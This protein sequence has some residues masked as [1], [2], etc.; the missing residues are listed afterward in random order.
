MKPQVKKALNITSYVL[1]G[2]MFAISL[3]MVVLSLT[4]SSDPS[5]LY[6]GIP[7]IGGNFLLSVQTDSMKGDKKD[8]FNPGA[9]VVSRKL[10]IS[11]EPDIGDIISFWDYIGDSS[12]QGVEIVN[13]HRVVG[14]RV[15][16][17]RDNNGAIINPID[18]DDKAAL[19]IQMGQLNFDSYEFITRGDNT[20]E[21][22]KD[23]VSHKRAEIIGIYRFHVGGL[24]SVIEF[25]LSKWGFFCVVI[26]PLL[27]FVVYRGFKL[28]MLILDLQK[29]KKV[30][31]TADDAL[32]RELEEL[33]RKVAAQGQDPPA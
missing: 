24:G 32:L 28:V 6:N 10:K 11:E 8:S 1:I 12:G 18:V 30:G 17:K 5:P 2:V 15:F 22:D 3:C 25:M 29:E 7:N 27:L 20:K 14:Y 9:L 4:S 26:L 16:F 23:P 19:T 21:A 33:R 31:V 13:T